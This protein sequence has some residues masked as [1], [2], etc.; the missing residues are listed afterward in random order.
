MPKK[1][2]RS[3]AKSPA[4]RLGFHLRLLLTAAR[5]WFAPVSTAVFTASFGEQRWLDEEQPVSRAAHPEALRAGMIALVPGNADRWNTIADA[6]ANNPDVYV[7][8]SY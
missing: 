5:S 1:T 6:L 7:M 3:P 4:R 8:V 2:G